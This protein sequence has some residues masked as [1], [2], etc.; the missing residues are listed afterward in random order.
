MEEE[1]ELKVDQIDTSAS[2]A[3]LGEPFALKLRRQIFA[4]IFSTSIKHDINM[5]LWWTGN[6][7][8]KNGD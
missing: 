1:E 6:R 8:G 2:V 5:I 4:L 3:A 7:Y